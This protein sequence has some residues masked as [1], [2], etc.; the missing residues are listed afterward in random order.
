[1]KKGAVILLVA[2]TVVGVTGVAIRSFKS[3]STPTMPGVESPTISKA[4]QR[5]VRAQQLIARMP[6]KSDGYNQLASAYMQKAR[7]TGDF[8]FNA[9][10]DDAITRSLSVESENY[11]ALKLRSKLQL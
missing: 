7:D 8:G 6:D 9:S 5:I 2:I 3:S 10:A 11:D 4:D 1:M